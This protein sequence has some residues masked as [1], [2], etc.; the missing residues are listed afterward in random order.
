M[1]GC[2][3]TRPTADAGEP[4]WT[5]PVR[6]IETP[7]LLVAGTRAVIPIQP[8]PGTDP[9]GRSVRITLDDGRR[10]KAELHRLVA[11]PPVGA[12]SWLSHARNWWTASTGKTP[13]PP[14][15]PGAPLRGGTVA[16]TVDVLVI[17]VPGDADG[18]SIMLEDSPLPI[19]WRDAPHGITA[20]PDETNSEQIDSDTKA[21]QAAPAS[22]LSHDTFFIG[23]DTR[24]TSATSAS[25]VSLPTLRS[26][27]AQVFLFAQLAPALSDPLLR[28]R[29]RLL[30]DRL[31]GE[32]FAALADRIDGAH[33][34][35]PAL[36]ALAAAQELRWRLAMNRLRAIDAALTDSM[37]SALTK[38]VAFDDNHIAPAWAPATPGLDPTNLG[39]ILRDALNQSAPDAAL[40]ARVRSLLSI[41]PRTVAWVDDDA[42]LAMLNTP[43]HL[44]S[45]SL[46]PPQPEGDTRG[47]K[48]RAT[49]DT[50]G[51]ES[52]ATTGPTGFALTRFR[53]ADLTGLGG[54]GW[55]ELD[56]NRSGPRVAI[57]PD[58][59]GALVASCD[60]DQTPRSALISMNEWTIRLPVSSGFTAAQPPGVRIAPMYESWTLVSWL[61][62]RP[63]PAPDHLTTAAILRRRPDATWELYLECRTPASGVPAG[64]EVRIWLGGT[65]Q[66][67]TVLRIDPSG[68]LSEGPEHAH[69]GE[70]QHTEIARLGAPRRP[71]NMP[72]DETSEMAQRPIVVT[73]LA[74]RWMTS[75]PIPPSAIEPTDWL[76]LAIERRTAAG[77]RL[78]WPR[79][80][81]PWSDS[82]GAR[83]I[84]L[85]AWENLRADTH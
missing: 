65:N 37:L 24:P 69:P 66:E 18:R 81:L 2:Q 75:V 30:A 57:A 72:P 35:D 32:G 73:H 6:P 52:R 25:A 43:L 80:R 56:P 49:T 74:D 67:R 16:F 78:T 58:S 38:L 55:A 53:L 22:G 12:P 85:S 46:V 34:Q 39:G 76:R 33:F 9:A 83:L 15:S 26:P 8:L 1:T 5:G 36:E 14:Q 70:P 21:D 79:P 13:V 31:R 63:I 50:R 17:D 40:I 4:V 60:L 64:D 23:Q 19:D 48:S 11:S 62:G 68:F 41:Q 3:A 29:I 45:E 59:A 82:P 44:T 28:W 7:A 20:L 47:S 84:D 54:I 42:G 10:L 77:E 27:T 61:S 71:E 51:S